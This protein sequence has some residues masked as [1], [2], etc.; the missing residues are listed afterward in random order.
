MKKKNIILSSIFFLALIGITF[1][2]I[3]SKNSITD[4]INS[5]KDLNY[6]YLGIIIILLISYFFLEGYFFKSLFNSMKIK[7]FSIKDG[8]FYAAAEFFFNAITPGASG[9]QPFILY[10]L[11]K[12][13]KIELKKAM[14]VILLGT[15]LFKVYLILGGTLVLIFKPE[16]VFKNGILIT[17]FF[18]LGFAL[19]LFVTA[20]YFMLM[21]NQKLI[22]VI[23]KPCL[24]I[25]KKFT[26]IDYE[27]KV[28][29]ELEK[30]IDE[31]IFIKKNKNKLIIGAL[32]TFL[33][34]T[35]MFSIIFVLYKA[36]GFKGLNYFDLLLLQIF[37]QITI[38]AVILPGG[39]GV[40][41]YVSNMLFTGIFGTL[42][43]STMLL[44]RSVSF[45]VP[46]LVIMVIVLVTINKNRK[47]KQKEA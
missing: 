18:F 3:F 29:T 1:Y 27:E 22:K 24:K 38:E 41:E 4:I 35:L 46:L 9:G 21:Y 20:F 25:Y 43:T 36:L 42:A 23:L 31:A 8:A 12:N 26:K 34:R 17:V 30:Y 19:D 6:F 45:Y 33:Q 28:N 37:V 5:L 14:I 39:T 47:K 16:Y 11:K 2:V 32:T 15:I 40:S 13:N 10:Y 44:Y 7:N